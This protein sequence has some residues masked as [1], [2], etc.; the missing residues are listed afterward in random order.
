MNSAFV[1]AHR[2]A[3]RQDEGDRVVLGASVSD[4]HISVGHVARAVLHVEPA[5]DLDFLHLLASARR[6]RPTL[7]DL[8][9]LYIRIDESNQTEL[10]GTS[11]RRPVC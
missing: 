5:R 6:R 4:W 10:S 7:D 8:V 9:F 1:V 11:I 3:A 2:R